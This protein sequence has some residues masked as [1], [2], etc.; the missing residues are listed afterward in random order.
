MDYCGGRNSSY[1]SSRTRSI[2]QRNQFR[3]WFQGQRLPRR[4]AT[5]L[6]AMIFLWSAVLPSRAGA[7]GSGSAA[8]DSPPSPQSTTS[9]DRSAQGAQAPSAPSIGAISAYEGKTVRL[10]EI[11]KVLSADRDH[12]LQL[13]PQK[14]GEPLDRGKVRDSLRVL[15]GTG[16][17]PT[18]RPMSCPRGRASS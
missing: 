11:S 7:H 9:P 15:Y 14:T 2:Q 12:L 3:V 10:I 8:Q 5:F 18:S 17:S 4:C 13:L 1:N 16:S 6:T